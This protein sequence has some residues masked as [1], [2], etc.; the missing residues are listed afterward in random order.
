MTDFKEAIESAERK[1]SKRGIKLTRRRREV[2][3]TLLEANRALSAYELVNLCNESSNEPMPAM[4]VY[5]ILEFLRA[6]QFVH[7]LETANKY[8][9]CKHI[10]CEHEHKQ[11]QFLICNDCHKVQE[12]DTAVEALSSVETAAS[13]LNF[14]LLN[15]QLEVS[16]SCG[17]C[18]T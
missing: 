10:A 3:T 5:R 15:P 8:I 11:P 9:A 13:M 14:K 7:K 4:S 18:K 12:L 2:L 6:E 17:L 1:C 16:G